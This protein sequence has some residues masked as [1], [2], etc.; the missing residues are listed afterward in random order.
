MSEGQ[1]LSHFREE[2]LPSR[3]YDGLGRLLSVWQAIPGRPRRP[4]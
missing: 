2:G 1:V 3:S 4:I